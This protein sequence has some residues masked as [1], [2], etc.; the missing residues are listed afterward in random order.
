MKKV[1]RYCKLQ[2]GDNTVTFD[3]AKLAADGLDLSNVRGFRITPKRM[4][5]GKFDSL[6]LDNMRLTKA[7]VAGELQR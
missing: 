2:P 5:D 3:M 6:V 1:G 7:G 4:K